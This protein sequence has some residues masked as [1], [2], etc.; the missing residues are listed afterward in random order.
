MLSL[1][2][3]VF[4]DAASK[5]CRP[6]GCGLAP[7]PGWLRAEGWAAVARAPAVLQAARG[8]PDGGLPTP[9]GRPAQ[10]PVRG[11][12]GAVTCR[13]RLNLSKIPQRGL[14]FWCVSWQRTAISPSTPSSPR[15]PSPAKPSIQAQPREKRDSR[16]RARAS[17]AAAILLL[18]AGPVCLFCLSVCL[19]RLLPYFPPVRKQSKTKKNKNKKTSRARRS[20]PTARSA[21]RARG[22]TG[23]GFCPG[24]KQQQQQ[25]QQQQQERQ[26]VFFVLRRTER[27]FPPRTHAGRQ[28]KA[29]Q[30]LRI[31]DH[32]PPSLLLPTPPDLALRV[33]K[34]P[35]RRR[36][37]DPRP[38]TTPTTPTTVSPE[39]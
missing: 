34:R 6:H 38:P 25:Q 36:S 30:G 14:F 24:R 8:W 3:H 26:I 35:R 29:M 5:G 12:K 9:A 18:G 13:L 2:G 15:G 10:A 19:S 20:R 4:L 28:G 39:A 27:A 17:A 23:R 21:G 1:I 11:T 37:S 31:S 32:P 16:P 7:K 22:L 33:D